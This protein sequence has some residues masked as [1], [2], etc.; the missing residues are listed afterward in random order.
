[1]PFLCPKI[2]HQ[3][4]K[5]ETYKEYFQAQLICAPFAIMQS[6]EWMEIRQNL[7]LKYCVIV[8]EG[9]PVSRKLINYVFRE[10]RQKRNVYVRMC[11]SFTKGIFTIETP[12]P[13]FLGKILQINYILYF[14]MFL[15]LTPCS[16]T[17]GIG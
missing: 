15:K 13:L 12:E 11:A 4:E 7:G 6:S 9:T 3:Y 16:E 17:T 10:L 8:Y 2:I 5:K 1:M 14:T